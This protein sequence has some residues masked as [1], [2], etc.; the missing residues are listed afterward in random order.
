MC[1]LTDADP[2]LRLR[3]MPSALVGD[4]GENVP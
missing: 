4:T 1:T 2:G 3:E